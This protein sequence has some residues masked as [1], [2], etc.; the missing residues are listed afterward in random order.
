[1]SERHSE[2]PA[3]VPV[4]V[5]RE[6]SSGRSLTAEARWYLAKT[7]SGIDTGEAEGGSLDASLNASRLKYDEQ[8]ANLSGECRVD[9]HVSEYR[10]SGQ[11]P[12][13]RVYHPDVLPPTPALLYLH[14]GG[15]V[16]GSLESHDAVCRAIAAASG[17]VV[18]AP[19]YRLAPENPFPA[20]L[21]DA[22]QTFQWILAGAKVDLDCGTVAV[23]GDS[24]GG[25]LAAVIA[26]WA[27]DHSGQQMAAQLLIY[28][29]VEYEFS[30]PS[31][32]RNARGYG[33]TREALASYWRLYTRNAKERHH[34]DASPMAAGN[35]AE[36]PDTLLVTAGFDILRDQGQ[37]YANRLQES[38][39]AVEYLDFP[40]MVHGFVRGIG[41]MESADVLLATIARFLRER[42]P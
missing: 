1:M 39:V 7:A 10:L 35:L 21:H 3:V 6:L 26:R 15:W 4:P 19:D 40:H 31:M 8:G 14:G 2:S 12:R 42:S 34:P 36:L 38:G 20:A 37:A 29:V 25:A 11:G 32:A 28:P 17:W 18:V 24:A 23:A 9:C 5:G 33:L 27:R 16:R 13:V 30:R 41:Q 22:W